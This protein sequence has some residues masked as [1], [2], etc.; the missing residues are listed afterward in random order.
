MSKIKVKHDNQPNWYPLEK[1]SEKYPN[2]INCCDFMHMGKVGG[3]ELY[4]NIV[5]R[6][7][8]N[9]DAEG[10]CWSYSNNGYFQI[11]EKSAIRKVIT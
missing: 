4:K 7:Y 11:T 8:I 2:Q 1:L 6:G 9:I 5:N 10:Y 3:I